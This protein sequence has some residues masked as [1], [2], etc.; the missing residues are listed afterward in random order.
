[1]VCVKHGAPDE[2][3]DLKMLP[4]PECGEQ[5]AIVH[6]RAFGIN[7]SDCLRRRGNLNAPALNTEPIGLELVREPVGICHRGC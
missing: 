6:V 1:M 2:A 7:R 4:Y 5:Q 3:F